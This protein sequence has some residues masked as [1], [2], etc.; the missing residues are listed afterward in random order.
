M[1]NIQDVQ[2]TI[3]AVLVPEKKKLHIEVAKLDQLYRDIDGER[4]PWKELGYPSLVDFL[5]TIKCLDIYRENGSHYLDFHGTD[6]TAHLNELVANQRTNKNKKMSSNRKQIPSHYFNNRP[7]KKVEDDCQLNVETYKTA[8]FFNDESDPEYDDI[9][10]E[11]PSINLNQPTTSD[12]LKIQNITETSMNLNPSTTSDKLKI[13]NIIKTSIDIQNNKEIYSTKHGSDKQVVTNYIDQWNDNNTTGVNGG[14]N[15][16]EGDKYFFD[17]CT[18]TRERLVKLIQKRP[19]G[20]KCAKLPD[21]YYQEYNEVLD[22]E[23]YSCDSLTQFTCNLP[24]IFHL[25]KPNAHGDFILY[26]VT[27]P[28]PDSIPDE[29]QEETPDP[30]RRNNVVPLSLLPVSTQI[31]NSCLASDVVKLGEYVKPFDT[32]DPQY[33][34]LIT[35]NWELIDIVDVFSPSFFWIHLH[36]LTS[37]SGPSPFEDMMNELHYF[38]EEKKTE[39]TIHIEYAVGLN[40]ACKF[41]QSWH[42][43]IIKEIITAPE[44]K[45]KVFFYD[46][47]TMSEYSFSD[48]YL[49]KRS[50]AQLP[51]QAI[52]CGL[53]GVRPIEDDWKPDDRRYFVEKVYGKTLYAMAFH[54]DPETNF[55]LLNLTD[56]TGDEDTHFNDDLVN[57]DI[58]ISG[59]VCIRPENFQMPRAIKK[60][61]KTLNLSINND[62]DNNSCLVPKINSSNIKNDSI[63]NIV[64][65]IHDKVFDKFLLV[66]QMCGKDRKALIVK[67]ILREVAQ[68]VLDECKNDIV[69]NVNNNNNVD[70]SVI[71]I[72][73]LHYDNDHEANADGV[74]D[75]DK[76]EKLSSIKDSLKSIIEENNKL[77]S[78]DSQEDELKVEE[79]NS[80]IVLP[81]ISELKKIPLD[82]DD[83]EDEDE[84][85]KKQAVLENSVDKKI[86]ELSSSQQDEVIDQA[87][88]STE[89]SDESNLLKT[90]DEICLNNS[91]LSNTVDNVFKQKE[92]IPEL[93]ENNVNEDQVHTGIGSTSV[94]DLIMSF[95]NNDDEYPQDYSS[96]S[97]VP[98]SS[99]PK[100]YSLNDYFSGN[101]SST[102]LLCGSSTSDNKNTSSLSTTGEHFGH[103][104]LGQTVDNGHP[105][106]LSSTAALASDLIDWKFFGVTPNFRRNMPNV[107]NYQNYA[108]NDSHPKIVLKDFRYNR[109]ENPQ[110][111]Q[112]V[113]HEQE[114]F[115]TLFMNNQ[116]DKVDKYKCLL[117]ENDDTFKIDLKNRLNEILVNSLKYKIIEVDICDES[118]DTDKEN[119]LPKIN[120]KKEIVKVENHPV[121][122]SNSIVSSLK[123][124]LAA[125]LAKKKEIN[126]A[127]IIVKQNACQMNESID[128]NDINSDE[129]TSE[130][131]LKVFNSSSESTEASVDKIPD[132]KII[133]K[134]QDVYQKKKLIDMDD[135]DSDDLTSENKSLICNSLYDDTEASAANE[136][137]DS[138]PDITTDVKEG[139][140]SCDD[141]MMEIQTD[142]DDKLI[143]QADEIK[144]GVSDEDESSE[145]VSPNSSKS[146]TSSSSSLETNLLS[147]CV[148]NDNLNT[149]T[150]GNQNNVEKYLPNNS[151]PIFNDLDIP[152]DDESDWEVNFT[153]RQV[154]YD[155]LNETNNQ[156]KLPQIEPNIND[157]NALEID[158]NDLSLYK[159]NW[160]WWTWFE[161]NKDDTITSELQQIDLPEGF[162]SYVDYINYLKETIKKLVCDNES[163]E[164]LNDKL[165]T[166]KIKNRELLR[167]LKALREN[168]KI[169]NLKNQEIN[170]E[171]MSLNAALNTKSTCSIE[172]D[173]T[174]MTDDYDNASTIRTIHTI[175]DFK[176][177]K[178]S[179]EYWKTIKICTMPLTII[180]MN[181]AIYCAYKIKTDPE[182]WDDVDMWIAAWEETLKYSITPSKII[183]SSV[184]FDDSKME[185]FVG[186]D[187]Q[188][189]E[190]DN[191]RNLILSEELDA[192][193]QEPFPRSE[194]VP[195]KIDRFNGLLDNGK[196]TLTTVDGDATFTFHHTLILEVKKTSTTLQD[197][198]AAMKIEPSEIVQ[199]KISKFHVYLPDHKVT[200]K[201]SKGENNYHL[202]HNVTLECDKKVDENLQN[203][204]ATEE[205]YPEDMIFEVTNVLFDCGTVVF[206]TQ[207]GRKLLQ[208]GNSRNLILSKELDANIQE[209]FPRGEPVPI[210]TG[211]VNGLL[212]NGKLT[213]KDG[214]RTLPTTTVDH[215]DPV[216]DASRTFSSFK[217]SG[218]FLATGNFSY[219]V[220]ETVKIQADE[221]DEVFTYYQF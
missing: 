112:Q 73:S 30:P 135:I 138:L 11:S 173:R 74:D 192:N 61:D 24:E 170:E 20:I 194:P 7:F 54:A 160:C 182:F 177:Q 164:V 203:I 13:Q 111:V 60:V 207:D 70:A 19:E 196:L 199:K 72:S 186:D 117:V 114:K 148:N 191:T 96:V 209:P 36:K 120:D 46:Y 17:I 63:T 97:G 140:D 143:T 133:V 50:F 49:L 59:S 18:K 58:A 187:Y 77:P 150:L 172:S 124:M 126:D 94:S 181:I 91:P 22:W 159:E 110:N 56:T 103:S 4:I 32:S 48:L 183:T 219:S 218:T 42:R 87:A 33:Q 116:D 179:A 205:P 193:I 130:N 147:D 204:I 15:N 99:Q 190:N 141:S 26:D 109:V 166:L 162:Q 176:T 151:I 198:I 161:A 25:V 78:L 93:I 113:I 171:R 208:N 57:K 53:F 101:V 10:E 85:D 8:T 115:Y 98:S 68:V 123:K 47:G 119:L 27:K 149:S 6:K 127:K 89:A 156:V 40:V 169:L 79:K 106:D 195:I 134:Q 197:E 175:D 128:M 65:K 107:R 136:T 158:L 215:S 213:L 45:A 90:N 86:E 211:G 214:N 83:D 221:S 69:E 31:K 43:G 81:G 217:L 165:E 157:D 167:E 75:D 184:L 152:S 51:V 178:K 102:S 16:E 129:L 122:T 71:D 34:R 88:T 104:K 202:I 14:D 29:L 132:V 155:D 200:L 121:V 105:E 220:E 185:I 125:S 206:K 1:K 39:Y 180:G 84:D 37:T 137:L 82:S 62:N 189:F 67:E 139:L 144:M 163:I 12:K 28:R 44:K 212:D 153:P 154:N 38:Y 80:S 108:K 52:P 76:E 142:N 216:K 41:D 174:I 5:V 35:R 2:D 188:E 201:T 210:K 23:D 146:D 64:N 21:I 92:K 55:L 9:F 95:D 100:T 168:K 118:D 131:K 145:D 3:L 66:P